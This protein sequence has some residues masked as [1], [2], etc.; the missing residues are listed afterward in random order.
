MS[1]EVIIVPAA[2]LMVAYVVATIAAVFTRRQQVRAS[3]EFH[4]R[5][6]DRVGNMKE[7][8]EFLNSDGGQQFLHSLATERGDVPHQRVLRALQTGVVLLFLGVGIFIYLRAFSI[9]YD[10]LEVF[11]FLGTVCTAVGIGLIVSSGI[12]YRLSRRMGLINGERMRAVRD[13]T[14]T[15]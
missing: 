11:G 13:V 1:S 9:D 4:T 15:A 7:F 3:S 10:A 6:M 2:F 5:L 14:P 8:G 12:S